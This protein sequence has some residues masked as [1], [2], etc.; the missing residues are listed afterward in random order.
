MNALRGRGICPVSCLRAWD[1]FWFSFEGCG[2]TFER[3]SE[4]ETGVINV[5][6]GVGVGVGEGYDKKSEGW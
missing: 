3:T 5:V 4:E 6:V 2:G 1:L